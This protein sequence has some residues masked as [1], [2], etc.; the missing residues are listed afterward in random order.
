M[1]E[2]QKK[3]INLRGKHILIG[4]TGGIAAYKTA[5]L[6]RYFK[7]LEADVKVVM[8]PASCDFITPLTLATLSQNPVAIELYDAK[9]GVW[10]NHVDLA[11]WADVM[12]IAPLTA[13]TL[14]KMATGQSDNLLLTT[15]LSTQCPVIVAPAMD[16]DMYKHPS[17][18]R[19]LA[20]LEKDGV[21]V[22]PADSG[23]LA[24]GLEGQGRMPEPEVIGDFVVDFL[25]GKQRAKGMTV[26]ITAGP[27]YEKIDPV[28]F[29]GNHSTG[30]MGVHLAQAFLA[31]GATV[32][33]VIGPSKLTL[34]HPNLER[35]DI[36]T[37]EE[38]LTAVQGVWDTCQ[39]GVFAA[40]VADY[41]PKEMA[42]QKLKK[43]TDEMQIEL[44][45][46]P[47]ILAWAGSVKKQQFLMGFALETQNAEEYAKGKIAAKNLD[48]IVVN[49]LEDK[50]AGFG[51]DTNKIKIINKRNKMSSFE[52]KLKQE[53]AQDIVAYIIDNYED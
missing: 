33:L 39:I 30:K 48:A 10:T 43:N 18:A 5:G 29:I 2:N 27:T 36:Q 45:K 21:T 51:H 31:E 17:T 42:S 15:Y 9:T 11:M 44:V 3:R 37:A 46:N 4:V 14:A 35:I 34:D 50:G 38:M 41:R 24:S 19:N 28:R 7:K 47:D 6:V 23:F 49:S 26:L 20:Q 13:N 40:A 12:V 1:L 53:V 25:Q 22:I 8:T 32:K 16:L 52:L